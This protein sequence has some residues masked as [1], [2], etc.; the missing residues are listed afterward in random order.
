MYKLIDHCGTILTVEIDEDTAVADAPGGAL[1]VC[2]A[3]WE[4][5]ERALAI[6]EVAGVDDGVTKAEDALVAAT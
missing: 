2:H 4:L 3:K 1:E 6:R 5:H